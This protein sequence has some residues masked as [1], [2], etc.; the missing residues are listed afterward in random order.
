MYLLPLGNAYANPV[1]PHFNRFLRT[2]YNADGSYDD[3]NPI[4]GTNAS[5]HRA[6]AA[7]EWY[8]NQAY[9]GKYVTYDQAVK[10]YQ[11]WSNVSSNI[12]ADTSNLWKLVGPVVGNVPGIVTYTGRPTTVSGRETALAISNP[13]TTTSCRVWVGA[14]G[15]GVWTTIDAL[16]TPPHWIWSSYG[17]P[18]NSIGSLFIDP[19][20]P[21][22]RIIY[23][24]TGEANGSSDSEAGVGLYKSTNYGATWGLLQGSITAAKNRAI[25]AVAVDPV[26]SKHIFIGTDV[27]RHGASSVNGGRFTPPDAPVVG[28]YESTNGGQ[29]F[30]LVFSKESDTVNPG[31][32]NGNDFFRGGVSTVVFD[33]TGLAK[34]LPSRVYFSVHD[35]GLYRELENEAFEQ[36][37]A[38]AGAGSIA[39]SPA[40]RTEFALAPMGSNLR[41]Y[42]GD[43]ANA[44]ADFYRVDN[45][46]VPATSLTDGVNNPG[47]TKLSNPNP[48]TPGY[49]SYNFCETQCSYDMWISSPPGQPDIVWYGG[50]MQYSEIFTP[51]PPSNGR[52]VMRSTDA[53]VNF[54]D[55]TNDTQTPPLGIHP[56]QHAVAFVPG[57]PNIAFLSSD[58]GLIRTDGTFTNASSQCATR[59]LTGAN[60]TD[61]RAWLSAIP[62]T[63]YSE[64]AGLATFQFQ[65]VTV[66]PQ[67]PRTDILGGTQDNGTWAYNANGTPQ[68]F[69]S[70]GGDGG[71][72][73]IDVGNTN[74]R[75]HT[76]FGPS[77]DVNFKGTDP[78][79]WDYIS[80]PLVASGEAASFYVPLI[81]DPQTSGTMFVGLQHVWRTTDNG[82]SQAIL[83]KNCNE[84]L[85][86]AV[87]PCGDWVPLGGDLTSAAYGADK[88]GSY[89]VSVE[90]AP[91]DTSTMWSATRLGRLFIS[92]NA[93]ATDP[94][95]VNFTR[96]DTVAQPGRFISGIAVDPK[97]PYHAYVSFSGYN[98]YT[99]ATPGHVFDVTYNPQT[100]KATWK[101]L[102]YNLGDQPITGVAFDS[103]K[104]TVYVSTDFGIAVLKGGSTHWKPAATGLPIATVAGLTISESGRVLYAATHG[105]GVWRLDI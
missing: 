91:S 53:G 31:S 28:L 60:L 58:G 15:G 59:G 73:V 55:M 66:N 68:W 35:Y 3:N 7:R 61:C 69:E 86:V 57:N 42:L 38:S 22:G 99:P 78:T 105:R 13:C 67:H 93:N 44:T 89:V 87:S 104:G 45:A 101:D 34:G 19:A 21:D 23:A 48:G 88:G 97:N 51:N 41:I 24:G 71:Q 14:A 96:I 25:G 12:A 74:V 27:A 9:P 2:N 46:N 63:L 75:M 10:A 100:G 20:T 17:I 76:Y 90:R 4:P 47:W 50:S 40:S 29:T 70:V 6:S 94:T 62:T 98:A 36:I 16:A 11:S 49:S 32:P 80:D 65:S 37:F 30:K 39:N 64:N 56:D 81:G 102:S 54:T 72:S 103:V 26:N 82:G 85:P 18:S 1:Q 95:T 79:G 84:L 83:D 77:I 5:K 33:R 52:A 8:D 43:L 92:N